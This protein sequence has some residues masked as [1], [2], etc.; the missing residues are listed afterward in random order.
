[1]RT[2]TLGAGPLLTLPVNGMNND[3]VNDY[4][5]GLK[6]GGCDRLVPTLH[7][8]QSS[9]ILSTNYLKRSKLPI[10]CK[11]NRPQFCDSLTVVDIVRK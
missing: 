11:Q 10:L 7:R 5:T 2:H 6:G 8:L 3:S 4:N 9:T 1:M